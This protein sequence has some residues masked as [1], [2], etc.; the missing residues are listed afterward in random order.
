MGIF[1]GTDVLALVVGTVLS[2]IIKNSLGRYANYGLKVGCS[3]L[4]LL[5]IIFLVKEPPK[6]VED[7]NKKQEKDK[8]LSI[9]TPFLSFADLFKTIFKRF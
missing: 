2:P 4:S 1:D 8:Q 9:L 3:A 5:Y 7:M 6:N